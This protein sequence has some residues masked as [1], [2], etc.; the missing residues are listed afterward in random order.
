[1]RQNIA[2]FLLFSVATK[3]AEVISTC[4]TYLGFYHC[5]LRLRNPLCYGE[6]ME[7]VGKPGLMESLASA[8]LREMDLGKG[9]TAILWKYSEALWL[10]CM[11]WL[12]LDTF[13]IRFSQ[14]IKLNLCLISNNILEDIVTKIQEKTRKGRKQTQVKDSSKEEVETVQT[15]SG[16]IRGKGVERDGFTQY[17]FFG[18]PYSK[19]PVG[20]LRSLCGHG[21]RP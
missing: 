15:R 20:S 17:Q 13:C 16:S 1:M 12:Q 11:C 9:P 2:I 6:K 3:V 19:P 14:L 4:S 7:G 18:N 21:P 8:T 5:H 10:R